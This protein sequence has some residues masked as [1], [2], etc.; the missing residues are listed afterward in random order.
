[1]VSDEYEQLSSEGEVQDSLLVMP[2]PVRSP[3][4]IWSTLYWNHSG[5]PLKLTQAV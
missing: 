3:S 5:E 1:M 2:I 4:H